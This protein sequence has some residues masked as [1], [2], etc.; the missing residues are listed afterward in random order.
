MNKSY[1]YKKTVIDYLQVS[2]YKSHSKLGSNNLSF[3]NSKDN[4]LE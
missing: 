2:I 1:W 4:A 3:S